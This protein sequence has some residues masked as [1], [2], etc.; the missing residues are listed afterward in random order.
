VYK[1]Y[2]DCTYVFEWN[3]S[4]VCGAVMGSWTPPCTIRDGFLSH[5]YDLSLLYKT[6]KIHYVSFEVLPRN[7]KYFAYKKH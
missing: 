7:V 5:E 2:I 4:I 1:H 6:R 3:T